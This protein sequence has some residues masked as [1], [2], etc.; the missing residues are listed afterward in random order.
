MNV[1]FF[2]C[3]GMAA[4]HMRN[5]AKF[6][7]S[8]EDIRMAAFCDIDADRAAGRAAEFGGR[9]Y[10]DFR[11]MLDAETLD[12]LYIG[13]P[14]QGHVGAEQAAA[15]R[16]VALFVEKPVANSMDTA[17]AVREAI[18]H[19]GVINS[20]GYNWRYQDTTEAARQALAGKTVGMAMGYWMGGMPGVPWW[21]R[22][23]Q[24]GGQFVEQTT[25]IFDA[26]RYLLGEI[27]EVTARAANRASQGVENF[28]VTD[29]GAA[30]VTFASGA[31]GTFHNTCLLQSMGYTVG[32]HVVTPDL[33]VEL[34]GNCT[35]ID[36]QGRTEIKSALNPY[37][38]EDRA[39]LDAVTK[40]DQSLI[41]S[42][43]ADAVETLAVTLAA[44]HSYQTG[45]SVRP[46]EL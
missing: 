15:E 24:S 2:G 21:R 26:A 11:A 36:A 45:Q 40:R 17:R 10:T 9:P 37:E 43:Y 44:N 7:D 38:A 20:V 13:V 41:R 19:A 3:G 34:S 22:L 30:L 8:G 27:T 42:P 1:G 6:R 12:A 33:I 35:L 23:D 16:D 25:H 46:S 14:P 5:V 28:T 4:G 32:L 29:V 31:V 39:F 18:A